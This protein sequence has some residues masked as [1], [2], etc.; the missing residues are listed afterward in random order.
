[1]VWY[2][3][4]QIDSKEGYLV[5]NSFS[6]I[7]NFLSYEIH[8]KTSSIP[9]AFLVDHFLQ[10]R[11]P[12]VLFKRQKKLNF[13]IM[14]TFL[15]VPALWPMHYA[16][17]KQETETLVWHFMYSK[18]RECYYWNLTTA[19]HCKNSQSWGQLSSEYMKSLG[20][21]TRKKENAPK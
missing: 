17:P 9:I 8:K 20:S 10:I 12:R 6:M 21:A 16:H 15:K 19:L 18:N 7:Y 13:T 4:K 1:M 3:E 11:T 14:K 5:G 2:R